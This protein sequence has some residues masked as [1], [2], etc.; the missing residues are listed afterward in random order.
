M[1]LAYGLRL[2]RGSVVCMW[3]GVVA[4]W[5]DNTLGIAG[6]AGK[7]DQL[8]DHTSAMRGRA[9]PCGLKGMWLSAE[10]CEAV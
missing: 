8:T 1:F 10:S 3:C 6:L 4:G 7:A 9:G 5:L 2:G